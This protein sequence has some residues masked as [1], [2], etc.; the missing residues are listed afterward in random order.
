MLEL[1]TDSQSS[2]PVVFSPE[3]RDRE[4][5]EEIY[6]GGT[7]WYNDVGLNLGMHRPLL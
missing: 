5:L 4:R 1:V 3:K 2:D 6:F 7:L